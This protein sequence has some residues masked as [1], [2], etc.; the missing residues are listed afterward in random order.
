M[1]MFDPPNPERLYK[2]Q[3]P[4]AWSKL[5]APISNL[6]SDRLLQRSSLSS[7]VDMSRLR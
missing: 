5:Y 2:D 4:V 3:F 7:L 6:L 1:L